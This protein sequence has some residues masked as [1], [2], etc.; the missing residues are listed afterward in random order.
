MVIRSTA[1]ELELA[2]L[3]SE[4]VSTVSHEF[5]TPLMSIR[6]LSEMLNAGRVKGEDKKKIYYGKINKESE[7]LSRLIENM[8]DFSKIE[9]GI[10][11]YTFE[12]LSIKDLVEEVS[13][14]FKEYMANKEVTLKC[15]IAANLPAIRA[16]REATSRA[17]F[18]LLDNAVKY[19]AKDPVVNLRARPEGDRVFLEVQDMGPGIPKAEQKKVFEKFYRSAD[20]AHRNI[21]GSGIGLTLVGHIVKAHG[22][23]V[24]MESD[25]GKGTR[26][27]LQF[28]VLRKGR[29]DGQDP[30]R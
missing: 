22:G 7:R 14:R 3:K 10:K 21:E 8:L 12:D 1:K 17:L 19:S 18:N 6:Y 27:T 15:E 24:M 30:D 11:K 4:F 28:P 20:P 25:V 9:A 29:E 13:G 23:D 16:D 5:R 2:R 26:V